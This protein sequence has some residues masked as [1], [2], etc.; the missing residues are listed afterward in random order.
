MRVKISFFV[1]P[2]QLIE[3]SGSDFLC[4]IIVFSAYTTEECGHERALEEAYP[5]TWTC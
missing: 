1:R 2:S 3:G 5:T 4:V